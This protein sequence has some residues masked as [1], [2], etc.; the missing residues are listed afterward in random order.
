MCM[1]FALSFIGLI[2]ML[3]AR[4]VYVYLNERFVFKSIGGIAVPICYTLIL[5]FTAAAIFPFKMGYPFLGPEGSLN[6]WTVK[7]MSLC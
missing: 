4:P 2:L 3:R 5:I 7:V 6:R 1:T